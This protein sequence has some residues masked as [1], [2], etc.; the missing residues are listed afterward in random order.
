[1]IISYT[2]SSLDFCSTYFITNPLFKILIC[3]LE[4]GEL[5]ISKKSSNNAKKELMNKLLGKTNLLRQE[6]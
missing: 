4:I 6:E 2:S 1:L 3:S 5:K